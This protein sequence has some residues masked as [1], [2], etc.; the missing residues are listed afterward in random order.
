MGLLQVATNTVTSAVA[1]VTLTGIDSD[2]PY[3]VAM[4]NVA[5]AGD[6]KDLY[7][8]YIKASDSSEDTTANYDFASKGLYASSTFQDNSQSNANNQKVMF[9]RGNATN[10]NSNCIIYLYNTFSSS[11]FSYNTVEANGLNFS[12]QFYGE[13]GGGVHTVAQSNSGVK[14]QWE[15][16]GNFTSGTFTLYK[17][18]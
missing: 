7:L 12:Q 8:N 16:G 18:V 3:M 17:V 6:N 13:Q 14:F 1:S 15:S 11:E 9:A 2:N 5:P 4:F 10:E